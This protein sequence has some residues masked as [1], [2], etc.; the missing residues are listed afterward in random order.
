MS[1]FN[2]LPGFTRTLAGEKRAVRQRRP[3]MQAMT[4]YFDGACPLCAAEIRMLAAR[5]RRQLLRFV[6]LSQ[7]GAE[8]PCAVVCAQAMDNIHAVLDD[9]RYPGRCAGIRRSLSPRRSALAGLAVFAALAALVTGAR[10][11]PVCPSPGQS[12]RSGGAALIA[13]GA[14]GL[15]LKKQVLSGLSVK[16][17]PVA[18]A[19]QSPVRAVP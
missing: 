14:V 18:G 7:P 3:A 11:R 1:I 2:H 12:L 17:Y 16:A 19:S 9:G 10:L 8:L 15:P 13:F 5:N 4:M 6:D